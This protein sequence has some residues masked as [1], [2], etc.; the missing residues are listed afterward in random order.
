[1]SY[2][3]VVLTENDEP[4]LS[5]SGSVSKDVTDENLLEAWHECLIKWHQNLRGPRPKQVGAN[6][7]YSEKN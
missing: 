5:G 6:I 3:M 4:L 7:V 1:M 2:I